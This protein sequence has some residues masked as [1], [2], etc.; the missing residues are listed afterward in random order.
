MH[1]VL[2][3][4]HLAS[5]I[6]WVGG[7]FFAYFCLRP[8]AVQLLQPPQRLPLWTQTF[9][10]FFRYVSLAL[11]LLIGSGLKMLLNVGFA[12]A[13][14]GWHA[15]MG[16]GLLMAAIFAYV[17]GALY[18]RLRHHSQA[19]EWPAAAAALNSIRRLVAVNL[20]LSLLVLIAAVSAR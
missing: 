8:A 12:D 16:L 4:L 13:P 20:F 6:I 17:Y 18:P 14:P 19:G 9:H 11:I 7:M 10:R 5:V 2:L 15:M 1:A 3:L